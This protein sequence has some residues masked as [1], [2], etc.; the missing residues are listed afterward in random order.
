M[1]SLRWSGLCAG[2]GKERSR[3]IFTENKLIE[4]NT[5]R[6][7]PEKEK[8]EKQTVKRKICFLFTQF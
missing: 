4:N 3:S 5:Y 7:N 8:P 6:N 2:K 1:E